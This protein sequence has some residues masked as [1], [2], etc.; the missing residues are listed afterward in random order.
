MMDIADVAQQQMEQ[1]E[2]QRPPRKAYS[3]P[4]GEPGDCDVC[5]TA[6][7]RLISGVCAPCRDGLRIRL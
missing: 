4:P 3:L 5:G 6:S 7:L 2:A 1:E